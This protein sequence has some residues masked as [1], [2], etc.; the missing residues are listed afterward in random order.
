M[1][2][3]LELEKRISTTNDVGLVA[4]LFERLIDNFINCK[5]AIDNNNYEKVNEL[6][7]HSRDILTELTV[8]FSED[9]EISL[10]LREI[11]NYINKLMTRGQINRDKSIFD[12]C[13]KILTPICEAFQQ[14]EV[15]EKPRA[16]TGLTY[17]KDNL[18]EHT[19]RKNRSFEG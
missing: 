7:N 3:I 16:V 2:D 19:L 5:D 13:I 9:D 1:T 17:G 4:I 11:N 14:L 10:T 6:N 8:L 18:D 15:A 12:V